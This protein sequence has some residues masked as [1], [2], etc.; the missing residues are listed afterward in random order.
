MARAQAPDADAARCLQA[1]QSLEARGFSG[2]SAGYGL[3]RVFQRRG[4]ERPGRFHRLAADRGYRHIRAGRER[5]A[6]HLEGVFTVPSGRTLLQRFAQNDRRRRFRF[7][8]RHPFRRAQAAGA[9]KNR[10]RGDQRRARP[11][12][13]A[14]LYQTLFSAGSESQSAGDGPR[15]A[16][17]LS[18]ENRKLDLDVRR[19]PRKSAGQAG[20]VH[21][22]PGLPRHLDRLFDARRGARRRP[23][24]YAPR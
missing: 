12:R 9:R 14:D 15:P 13:R 11:G 17:R 10:N 16:H 3:E 24:Q 22:R 7:L 21:S 1:E 2:E 5:D 18:R 4:H 20:R 23:R 8:R 19:D 6:R